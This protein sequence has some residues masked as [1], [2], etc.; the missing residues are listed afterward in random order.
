V[1]R[2]I[3][4]REVAR[5]APH[6]RCISLD[7]PGHYPAVAPDGYRS[8]SQE[9]LLDLE[10]NAIRAIAGDSRVTLVG[11]STGGLVALA[12]AAL[13]PEHVARVIVIA[14]VVWGPLSGV[15]GSFQ[16]LLAQPGGYSLFWLNYRMCQLSLP[17]IHWITSYASGDPAA[18]RRSPLVVAALEAFYPNCRRTQIRSI[19]IML[20][21]LEGCD[22]RPLVPAITC[23][24]LVIAGTRDSLVPIEQARWLAAS[25]PSAMLLE[26]TTAGHT[27]HWEAAG[28]VDCA[29]DS[30]LDAHPLS[31]WGRAKALA[32]HSAPPSFALDDLPILHAG[33][34]FACDH[35]RTE[36]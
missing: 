22:I 16:R 29:I 10:L 4:A 6:G 28:Q 15:L 27:P 1:N 35:L 24:T 9:L 33:L 3:W 20:R 13:L 5:M 21:M 25:L 12:A 14:P 8:L 30:W 36:V 19:A 7:L 32:S 18:Y 34:P 11:H 17:Y 23:P 31:V 2:A 26:L